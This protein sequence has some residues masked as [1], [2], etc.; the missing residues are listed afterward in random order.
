MTHNIQPI[1]HQSGIYMSADQCAARWPR[2]L[3]ACQYVAILSHGEAAAAM[4]D[5]RITR[6]HP[7]SPTLG[8][9]AVAHYGGPTRVIVDAIRH[10]SRARGETS[11]D[12]YEYEYE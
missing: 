4:R 9:D 11:W 3:R 7:D 1:Y 12:R 8:C 2:L 10:R 6:R 5:Y